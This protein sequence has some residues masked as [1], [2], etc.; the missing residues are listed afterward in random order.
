MADENEHDEDL[1]ALGEEL[2]ARGMTFRSWAVHAGLRGLRGLPGPSLF[3]VYSL[4][5]KDKMDEET[6]RT[7]RLSRSGSGTRSPATIPAPL[8]LPL[9]ARHL[10]FRGNPRASRFQ[11]DRS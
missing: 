2:R 8:H 3:V 4:E 6:C 9:R 11:Q 10:R 7:N 1:A 5:D